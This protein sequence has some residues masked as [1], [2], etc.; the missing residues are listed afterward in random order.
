MTQE[1]GSSQKVGRGELGK[2]TGFPYTTAHTP[3]PEGI[4]LEAWRREGDRTQSSGSPK[5]ERGPGWRG[6]ESGSRLLVAR[7]QL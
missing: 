3:P 7:K 6:L 2:S 1:P 5:K 4:S